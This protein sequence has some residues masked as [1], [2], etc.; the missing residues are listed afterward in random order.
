[1]PITSDS[2]ALEHKRPA[3]ET[4]GLGL[5][6]NPWGLIG[7]NGPA[8]LEDSIYILRIKRFFFQQFRGDPL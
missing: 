5:A 7:C 4:S 1:M 6:E 8:L 2:L 3:N